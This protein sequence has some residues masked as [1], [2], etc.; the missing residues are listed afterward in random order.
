M[1]V[2]IIETSI[3][4]L[5][6]LMSSGSTSSKSIV[7]AYLDEIAKVD[8]GGPC[9]NSIIELNPDVLQ[10]AEDLDQ[11]RKVNGPRSLLHGIPL[12]LKDNIDTGDNMSTTA[13]SLAL[14]GH[15]SSSDASL[16]AKLRNLGAVVL[17]KT[18]LSEWA[19]FRSTKP[20]SGWSSRG[21]RTLNPYVLDRSPR[22]SSAGSAVAVAANLCAGAIGTET[23]GSIMCPS[24]A[25]C[26]VGIKPTVGLISQTGIIPLSHSQDTAG[27]IARTVSDAAI[28]L[29]AIRESDHISELSS[30]TNGDVCSLY[31]DNL[32]LDGLKGV[33]LG[34]VRDPYD[35]GVRVTE[36]FDNAIA[37]MSY[38]GA[39]VVESVEVQNVDEL[40]H[41]EMEVL[42]YE[43]KAGINSYLASHDH[44]AGMSCLS[45]IISYNEENSSVVMK[46]FG[47]ELFVM[48]EDKGGLDS[49]DYLE[50]KAENMR[51]AGEEGLNLAIRQHKLDA[52]LVPTGGLPWVVDVLN[53]DCSSGHS[54]R[55]AAVSGYPSISV[56]A[57]YVGGL[58]VGISF[59][60]QPYQEAKLI[61]MAFA[62]EQSTNVRRPPEFLR[63]VSI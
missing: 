51:L 31:T 10:I 60:G 52:V 13:G 12:V 32:S 4:D 45:D 16:V 20:I 53:G 40:L 22:G 5:Q 43:F 9:I 63:E 57:G 2:D 50:A 11:E 28:I 35:F 29:G 24:S 15:K 62:Y 26:A 18:N 41:N 3:I 30:N 14:S 6:N 8:D 23:D 33:R 61:K 59:I 21:N 39:S 54:C 55:P 46:Y 1:S 25:T 56:P 36:I 34:I 7:E 44:P 19:N 42:L 48:A 38:L 37:N 49:K 58:P 47:Q 17:A 27:P